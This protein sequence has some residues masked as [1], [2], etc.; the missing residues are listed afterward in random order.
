LPTRN[1]GIAGGGDGGVGGGGGGVVGG[2]GGGGGSCG[3]LT[4]LFI[5]LL[6]CCISDNP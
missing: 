4:I 1:S 2:G 3:T 5:A 6:P